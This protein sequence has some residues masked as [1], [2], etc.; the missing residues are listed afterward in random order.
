[1]A[2]HTGVRNQTRLPA[3]TRTP[4][5]GGIQTRRRNNRYASPPATMPSTIQRPMTKLIFPTP[6]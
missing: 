3:N 1:M 6:D 2:T 5:A 4:T